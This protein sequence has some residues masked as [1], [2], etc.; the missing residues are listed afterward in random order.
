[1][2]EGS[3]LYKIAEKLAN[4]FEEKY[5][6]I[7]NEGACLFVSHSLSLTQ[8]FSH[9]AFLVLFCFGLPHLFC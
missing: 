3:Y 4:K 7:K 8:F 5:S 2:Q 9:P 6:K 1:M